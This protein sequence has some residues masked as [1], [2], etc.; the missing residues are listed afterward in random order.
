MLRTSKGD[1]ICTTI[2]VMEDSTI[3]ILFWKFTFNR[4]GNYT[5]F[6]LFFNVYVCIYQS[7]RDI[8]KSKASTSNAFPVHVRIPHACCVLNED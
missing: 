5:S 1:R 6:F 2:S 8:L 7:S 3:Y 4:T